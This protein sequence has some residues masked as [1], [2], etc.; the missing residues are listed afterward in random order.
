MAGKEHR[1]EKNTGAIREPDGYEAECFATNLDTTPRTLTATIYDFTGA[2]VTTFSSCGSLQGPGVT[3]RSGTTFHGREL[4]CRAAT[5][6]HQDRLAG[7][8]NMYP[9]LGA[10]TSVS[11]PAQDES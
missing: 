7:S 5:S 2:N 1:R 4:R 6:G 10:P 9:F 11:L 8:F 3:C